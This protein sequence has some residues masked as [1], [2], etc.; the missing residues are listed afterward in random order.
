MVRQNFPK[1]NMKQITIAHSGVPVKIC[2]TWTLT[3][4]SAICPIKWSTQLKQKHCQELEEDADCNWRVCKLTLYYFLSVV[5]RTNWRLGWLL[6]GVPKSHTDIDTVR[7]NSLKEWPAHYWGRYQHNNNKNYRLIS[8]NLSVSETDNQNEAAADLQ[9]R[10][11]SQ[12]ARC[13][14]IA[15]CHHICVDTLTWSS[16]NVETIKT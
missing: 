10:P 16:R 12:Q 13:T 8:M 9:I 6:V 3:A 1:I 11:H 15:F 7:K 4:Y 5:M 14:H 2:W